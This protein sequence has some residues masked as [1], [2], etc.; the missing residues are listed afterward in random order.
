VFKLRYVGQSDVKRDGG[1]IV[2]GTISNWRRMA[3]LTGRKEKARYFEIEPADDEHEIAFAGYYLRGRF[4][5]VRK[6]NNA[7]RA[8]EAYRQFVP[9]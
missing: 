1:N 5:V 4:R 3:L 2:V 7:R 8:R 9:A 6:D